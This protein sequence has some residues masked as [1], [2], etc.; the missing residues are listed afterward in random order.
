MIRVLVADDHTVV[1]RGVLQILAEAPD[2]IVAEEAST[3]H[4]ALRSAQKNDY[5]VILLDISMPDI[6]GLEVLKQLRV[7]KPEQKVLILSMYPESQYAVRALKAG[8]SGYLTKE[9][10]PD[11]LVAAV[12]KVS[13]GDR[14][15][16]LS[17]AEELAAQL[18]GEERETLSEDL[19]DRE[20]QVMRLLALGKT[21]TEV[22]EELSLSTKTISTYRVRVLQKLGLRN[23]AEIIRYAVERGLVG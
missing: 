8:A 7:F 23:T 13:R 15:I 5:D 6:N 1:R 20:Y 22:A 17:L 9:S 18:G 14:Y 19:S 10:A 4:D 3:G 11:E 21:V 12:R 16:T 2:M